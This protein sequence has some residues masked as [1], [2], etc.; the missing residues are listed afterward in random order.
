MR[1]SPFVWW[2]FPGGIANTLLAD[3][4]KPHCDVKSDNLSLSFSTASSVESVA[5]RISGLR[6]DDVH[7]IPN[8][9]AMDDL[10]FSECLSPEIAV[11]VFTSRFDDRAAVRQAIEERRRIVVNSH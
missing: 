2:T 1:L 5:E 7:P 3:T 9:D 8:L 10:K 11:E 6:P 4:L